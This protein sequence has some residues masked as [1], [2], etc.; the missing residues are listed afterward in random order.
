MNDWPGIRNAE[1]V[2]DAEVVDARGRRIV[3][4]AWMLR[5]EVEHGTLVLPLAGL[6]AAAGYEVDAAL[7]QLAGGVA[8]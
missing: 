6:L 4:G 5:L 8:R 1:V 3:V 7:D 2:R